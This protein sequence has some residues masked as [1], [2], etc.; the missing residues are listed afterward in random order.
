[1]VTGSNE[2]SSEMAAAG[3]AAIA[4]V[5]AVDELRRA[6]AITRSSLSAE[7]QFT[8]RV[9][10]SIAGRERIVLARSSELAA[11]SRHLEGALR[12]K[13]AALD[14]STAELQSLEQQHKRLQLHLQQ[15]AERGE[16]REGRLAAAQLEV[17]AL[18]A[19]RQQLEAEL[20]RAAQYRDALAAQ[21]SQQ[22]EKIAELRS[23]SAE[24]E[25]LRA[26]CAAGPHR[27]AGNG[28]RESAA[29]QLDG[30]LREVAYLLKLTEA[31]EQHRHSLVGRVAAALEFGAPGV[32]A[33]VYGSWP[34]GV[35]LPE[36]DLDF[37]ISGVDAGSESQA[38]VLLDIVE[39]RM[40]RAC[41]RHVATVPPKKTA[42]PVATFAWG[43][44]EVDLSVTAKD[45]VQASVQV[46]RWLLRQHTELQALA[47]TVKLLLSLAGLNKKRKGGVP[48][49]CAVL[50]AAAVCSSNR[51]CA[52]VD[53]FCRFFEMFS[54]KGHF[55]WTQHTVEPLLAEGM[56]FGLMSRSGTNDWCV[57]DAARPDNNAAYACWNMARVQQFFRAVSDSLDAVLKGAHPG[58]GG[59]RL[60]LL[61]CIMGP[62]GRQLQEWADKR[63]A[64][65][66]AGAAH[67]CTASLSAAAAPWGSS[68]TAA[69]AASG[70]HAGR[71]HTARRE[72]PQGAER[73]QC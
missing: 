34:S 10:E 55:D 54:G 25:A 32:S 26:L 59:E 46:T 53:T 30:E 4:R 41:F 35:A 8:M 23:L 37:C 72:A 14:R 38:G 33:A 58:A 60:P 24:L 62:Y 12:D 69:P 63:C 5:G 29:L 40:Q 44:V 18:Q 28:S 13:N 19:R 45:A 42:V 56:S 64:Q 1:M 27:G 3:R 15:L 68:P 49:Y 65:L 70:A 31:E 17:R 43:Q 57:R 47:V 20:A 16:A 36:S 21:V 51:G 48:S 11:R 50:M 66:R 2:Q 7:R 73:Q 39:R 71:D 9:F 6:V 52:K 67:A 61:S 22:T